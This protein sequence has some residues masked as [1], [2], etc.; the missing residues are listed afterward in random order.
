VARGVFLLCAGLD[1]DLL[2]RCARQALV[3]PVDDPG[4]AE[5]LPAMHGR[6]ALRGDLAGRV[7]R[8]A[9]LP[10]AAALQVEGDEELGAA[11]LARLLAENGD[12]VAAS[13]VIDEDAQERV[14][15][16]TPWRK[17]YESSRVRDA[18]DALGIG[19]A[20]P[21]LSDALAL[22]LDAPTTAE[23]KAALADLERRAGA[24]PSVVEAA[25]GRFLKTLGVA[26]L[27]PPKKP[28]PTPWTAGPARSPAQETL[29][30]CLA[31]IG[32][33]TLIIL[34]LYALIFGV[35]ALAG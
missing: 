15:V 12:L 14:E 22:P 34:A 28:K 31:I 10:G 21:P 35:A 27:E 16:H 30:G 1:A 24:T 23:S 33:I 11:T 5:T 19:E 20:P 25:R 7:I 29:Q 4:G 17:A 9:A 18:C 3:D 8:V 32:A 26:D 6:R 2:V 13:F